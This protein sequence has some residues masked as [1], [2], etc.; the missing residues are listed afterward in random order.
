[1]AQN[2]QEAPTGLKEE[3]VSALCCPYYWLW[4]TFVE[5]LKVS[6]GTAIS[7]LATLLS[8]NPPSGY[9]VITVVN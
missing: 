3:L 7:F 2:P 9:V 5:L 8:D 6:T 1:M 4:T